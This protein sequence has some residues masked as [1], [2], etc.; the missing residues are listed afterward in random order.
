MDPTPVFF[1]WDITEDYG[2]RLVVIEVPA[3]LKGLTWRA[4]KQRLHGARADAKA[5][6]KA[7]IGQANVR[8]V[9]KAVADITTNG[10]PATASKVS[11]VC[12]RSPTWAKPY[13][14][15]AVEE[16][17]LVKSTEQVARVIGFTDVYRLA[18]G[19]LPWQTERTPR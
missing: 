1:R 4:L 14:T 10:E 11:A 18:G 5:D 16:G 17:A 7:E 3:A 2:P 8:L 19:D 9:I 12:G 6:K 15:A 13:L